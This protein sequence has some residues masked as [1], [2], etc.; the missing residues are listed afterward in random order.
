MGQTGLGNFGAPDDQR[1]AGEAE[2]VAGADHPSGEALVVETDLESVSE[3]ISLGVVQVDY[4]IE[5]DA[6]EE[7]PIIHLF[8]RQADGTPEH[9]RVLGFEPY[10]YIPAASLSEH[11][12]D[13]PEIIRTEPGYTSI[14]GEPLVRV[15]TRTPRDVG[16]IRDAFD[17]FE[18]DILF[19]NRLLIDK[20]LTGGVQVPLRRDA[21]GTLEAHHDELSPAAV[22]TPVRLCMFDI[23]VDDRN[24]FPEDG[25]EPILCLTSYDSGSDQY[26]IWV[27]EPPSGASIPDALPEYS[28]ID[29]SMKIE[30]R[31]FAAEDSM[32]ARFVDYIEETNPDILSGWNFDDFDLPYLLDRMQR[33][34]SES[35]NDLRGDRL[36]RV[37][38]VWRSGWGGPNVKGRVVFDLLYAYKR[39]Q[40]T[41]LD[42]YRLDAVGEVELGVGKERYTGAIGDLWEQDPGR[43]I[44]YNLRDV[45]LCVALNRKRQIISFW[46]EVAAF[47]GCKLEDAPTPGDAVDMFVLH[48]AYGKFVLPSK[49]RQDAEE[50]EGGAVFDPISGVREMVSVLDLKSLY[51]MSMVTMNASPETRVDPDSYDGPTYTAPTGQHFRKEPDGIMREMVDELLT[52]REEKKRLRD[53]HPVGSP[54]YERFDQQQA[55]VKIIMNSLYGVSGWARFRLYDRESAAAVTATGREVIAFTAEA[56][57]ELGHT[58]VYGDTDSVMIE[59]GAQMDRST[60][61]DRSFA[62]EDHLNAAY[63][64][65]ASDVLSADDHRFQIEFEKLYRRFFQA[66]KKKRYAG[67]IIWKEGQDVDAIDITG[68]EYKRSDIAAITKQVQREVIEKIVYGEEPDAIASY[69]RE[70]IDAFEAGTI[71]LDAVAI[72]GGIGKRL[73]A[74]ETATAHVR[75]AQ[76]ANAVLG[77]SFARGSKPKRVYLRKVHPA[78]FRQLEAEGLADPTDDPVYAEFKR[79]P[80]VICFEYADEVPETFAVDYDR[81]LEKTVRAPIERI[82][83]ALGMQWDE[84]RSGQEQT[85]LESFF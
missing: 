16:S 1:P 17:H 30:V 7:V 69:L 38:E 13:R 66:G 8:G 32:L 2:A 52:E 42:S 55:S 62:I 5:D 68:F 80:D 58:V 10:F 71:D 82:V 73:D 21:A 76:Y 39:T 36:S 9:V 75:G 84:I 44:E 19:P 40:L 45:E 48:K 33:L 24:G 49:G 43:L 70:V 46:R 28:P 85:G 18:A 81:M 31:Q 79:D 14:R 27:V 54:E 72:P 3:H 51:P 74:Y 56:T 63:D 57:R 35:S 41:E 78:F 29:G 20:D 61:I 26:I 59:L 67:H 60:A 65:F 83:E 6:G 11:S 50:F 47:V 4:T 64:A 77:T 15:Y 53:E 22:D 25:E 37:D 23:E 12:L 34:A